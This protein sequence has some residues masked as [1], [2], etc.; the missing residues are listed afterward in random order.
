MPDSMSGR[1]MNASVTRSATL[2]RSGRAAAFVEVDLRRHRLVH[3]GGT[4][5]GEPQRLAD[6]ASVGARSATGRAP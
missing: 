2:A 6:P 5:V 3:A 4:R 1:V